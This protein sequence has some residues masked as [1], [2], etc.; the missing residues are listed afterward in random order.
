MI[1]TTARAASALTNPPR[2][3]APLSCLEGQVFEV[4]GV[5]FEAAAA[6]A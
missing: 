4:G 2:R 5:A 3:G 1:A 6:G